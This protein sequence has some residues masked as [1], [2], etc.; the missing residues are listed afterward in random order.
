MYLD[1]I[2][3]AWDWRTSGT[4]RD[5]DRLWWKD[6][7]TTMQWRP[8]LLDSP[9][10]AQWY[11]IEITDLYNAWQDSTC[12]NYGVQLRPAPHLNQ[13]FN[14]FY[15]AKYMD[16]AALR[17]K[18]LITPWNEA[19]PADTRPPGTATRASPDAP[20]PAARPI[21]KLATTRNQ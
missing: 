13:R 7:P 3:Q 21:R 14:E 4:G 19:G 5:H 2:T 12:S 11:P 10:Q 16:D 9:R 6:K 8:S 17:P 15:S 1:R 18:L 20:K